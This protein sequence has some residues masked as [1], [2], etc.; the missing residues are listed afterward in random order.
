[1]EHKIF[2]ELLEGG[3][4]VDVNRKIILW[5]QS[6]SEI[7]GY[8]PD[9]VVG[10]CCYMN[11]LNHKTDNG[12]LL[13]YG[14]CPL[15]KSMEDNEIINAKVTL[16]HKDGH[17]IPINVRTVPVTDE[18]GVVNGCFEFF[19][20]EKDDNEL[21]DSVYQFSKEAYQDVLTE[22]PNRRYAS[23]F[24]QSKINEFVNFNVPFVLFFIDIDNFKWINDKYGHE[25]GDQV[26]KS[27]AQGLQRNVRTHDLVSRWGGDE[28]IVLLSGV[29][30]DN[31]SLVA[32]KVISVIN[33]TI[34]HIAESEL[35]IIASIGG[36]VIKIDDTV[37]SVVQ[38]ADQLMY[39]SK[40]K[41]KNCI[42]LG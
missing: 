8:Q 5:N 35:N 11:F 3:Y 14:G 23:I 33:S 21:M 20:V 22:L 6:A 1:M 34:Y 9:D 26:L 39:Q 15:V 29:P 16:Q 27:V 12:V 31:L 42:T 2:N 13:C 41:G 24:I 37:D 7:T 38:R 32:E 30:Y 19:T 10:N 4:Y 40:I 36:T 25:V 17:R 18:L 28:F